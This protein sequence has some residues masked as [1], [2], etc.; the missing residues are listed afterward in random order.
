M[1]RRDALQVGTVP[2]VHEIVPQYLLKSKSVRI[3]TLVMSD[4]SVNQSHQPVE[5]PQ[6]LGLETK[7]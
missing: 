4:K 3:R 6:I 7:R 1:A 5:N 2:H